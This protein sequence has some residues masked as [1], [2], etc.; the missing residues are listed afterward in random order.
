MREELGSH[1]DPE[2]A[3]DHLITSAKAKSQNVENIKKRDYKIG[4]VQNL[5]LRSLCI[6]TYLRCLHASIEYAPTESLR[7]EAIT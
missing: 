5:K 7:L 2:V 3:S 4:G 1:Y 6:A